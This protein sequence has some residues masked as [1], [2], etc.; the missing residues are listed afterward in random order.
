MQNPRLASRYAKSLLDLAI[1]R[2]CLEEALKDMRFIQSICAA[3]QEFTLV[4]KSPVLAGAK[5]L[6]VIKAVS[7]DSLHPTTN[8]FIALVVLKGREANL[9]SIAAAF[10]ELY[11]QLKRIRTVHLST[12]SPI[13]E[14]AKANILAKIAAS[15]PS[16]TFELHTKI[17]A[18]LI[19]GFVLEV[20]DRFFDASIKKKLNDIRLEIIDTSYVAKLY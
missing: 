3:S 12:A 7:K 1:E 11:N 19:G 10:V 15:M 18:S 20:G 17:D 9:E 5:K 14:T 16:Y 8:A 13:T 4:L 2:N 6:S